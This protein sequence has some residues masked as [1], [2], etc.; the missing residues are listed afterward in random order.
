MHG[1]G[2]PQIV[3]LLIALLFYSTPIIAIIASWKFYQI[4]SR[5]ND[6]L[7]AIRSAID[8]NSAGQMR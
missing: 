2:F 4:L 8:R 5:M 1:I 6:N 7:S 3:P